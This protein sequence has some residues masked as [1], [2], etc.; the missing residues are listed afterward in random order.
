MEK[1]ANV[2]AAAQSHGSTGPVAESC[3]IVPEGLIF[4][5]SMRFPSFEN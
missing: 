3:V 4:I 5:E 1:E 2:L